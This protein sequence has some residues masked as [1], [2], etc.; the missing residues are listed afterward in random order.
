MSQWKLTEIPEGKKK[1]ICSQLIFNKGANAS[2]KWKESGSPPT[3]KLHSD[4][5]ITTHRKMNLDSYIKTTYYEIN[6]MDHRPKY[7][8]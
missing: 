1:L 7:E 2:Q 8:S 3:K 6:S 4:N 5:W